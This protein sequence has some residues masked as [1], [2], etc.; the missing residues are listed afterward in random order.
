MERT[1]L[2]LMLIFW[3]EKSYKFLSFFC[4]M[5]CIVLQ[6]CSNQ[7]V[8]K[9]LQMVIAWGRLVLGCEVLMNEC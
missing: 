8:M 3:T 4:Q 9:F 6:Y 7:V 5:V 2:L 1:L